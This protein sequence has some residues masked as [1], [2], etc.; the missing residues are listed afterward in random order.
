VPRRK[1]P[2]SR[3]GCA[4]LWA[5]GERRHPHVV[6]RT[7]P[8]RVQ[9]QE[10]A[11]SPGIIH[12]GEHAPR[13]IRPYRPEARAS[14]FSSP[15]ASAPSSSVTSSVTLEA[16]VPQ[17]RSAAV[18]PRLTTPRPRRYSHERGDR[19]GP[20]SPVQ[21]TP[22]SPEGLSS[23]CPGV[24]VNTMP[25]RRGIQRLSSRP[26]SLGSRARPNLRDVPHAPRALS[27][28]AHPSQAGSES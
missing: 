7:P 5:P 22:P 23:V 4:C 3:G 26:G 13:T 24:R 6:L 19:F 12:H 8:E 2:R 18:P 20:V 9:W 11:P 14:A 28:I 25:C 17:W 21:V 27:E 1:R 10:P 16:G 15:S